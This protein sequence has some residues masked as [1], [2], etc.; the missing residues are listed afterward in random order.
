MQLNDLNLF[1]EIN[2]TNYIFVVGRHDEDQNFKIIE[3]IVTINKEINI[4]KFTNINDASNI[5]KKNIQLIEKKLNFVF[6]DVIIILDVFELNCLNISGFKKLNGSQVK[7]ENISYILNSLKLKISE[8]EKQKTILHIFNSKSVL[9]GKNIENLPIGLFG[10]FYSHELTFFLIKKNDLKNIKLL[11]NKNNLEVKK[12]FIKSFSEGIE[13]I[14]QNKTETFFKI[15]LDKNNSKIIFFDKSSFRYSESFEFG[16]DIIFKD[17][18]KICSIDN[19]TINN[20]LFDKPYKLKVLNKDEFIEKKY[21]TNKQYRKIK[22]KL[23]FDIVEARIEEILDIILYKNINTYSFKKKSIK[24]Y[25]FVKEKLILDNFNE[26]FRIYFLK[27]GNVNH[28][29]V[30][31]SQDDTIFTNT[32]KLSAYGWSKEAIPVSQ[33]KNSLIS[34]IFKYIF[35]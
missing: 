22:K 24:I 30:N 28:D 32:A 8:N 19:H 4:N 1:I 26:I 6:K 12:I 21:F 31:E 13:L 5:I 20:Y 11:F 27:N 14:H 2:D 18:E 15:K 17:I 35:D 33:S 16:T 29:F 10:D 3:K 34:R 7:K 23:I 9:D 25:L